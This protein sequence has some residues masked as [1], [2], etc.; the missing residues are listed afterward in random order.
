M[1]HLAIL[2]NNMEINLSHAASYVLERLSAAG[3]ESYIVGGSVRDAMMGK[4]PSD[5]DVA[6][7]ALP[8]ETKSLF[9]EYTIFENGK[10]H[11]TVGVVIDGEVIEITTFRHD[12]EYS[13]HRHPIG[14]SF[15]HS[16][17]EDLSRRDFTVNAMA[18]NPK[19]G[20]VDIF[21][22]K[23]DLDREIIRCVGDARTRFEEDALRI[24]RALRF[25][26]VLEFEIASDTAV[27]I[28]EKKDLLSFVS[29]E[30]VYAEIKKLISGKNVKAIIDEFK[31]VFDVVF[32][33]FAIDTGALSDVKS[34][35][36]RFAVLFYNAPEKFAALKPS[37]KENSLLISIINVAKA[38]LPNELSAMRRLVL[39]AGI[40]AFKYAL[41]VKRAMGV[42]TVKAESLL[43]IILDVNF[44][45]SI[46]D[47]KINGGDIIKL[48][49]PPS[50]QIGEI[51]KLLFDEVLK[52]TLENK[53]E[54][55]EVRAK[56][57]IQKIN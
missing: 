54:A 11:G 21:G 26:S 40:E 45:M 36:S 30:R 25:A 49:V 52:G 34:D 22:G 43:A 12:G 48:G 18:Y 6:T 37:R 50:K 10:R 29:R 38:D 23:E 8:D 16:L 20:I 35:I 1:P 24:L 3:F 57:L 39:S 28:N 44:C 4:A 47:L 9:E 32:G 15:T 17:E 41:E 53:K 55:L 46:A 2:K 5:F 7:N 31:G 56:E 33:E 19:I 14:V 42:S 13:D 27:A 51:L